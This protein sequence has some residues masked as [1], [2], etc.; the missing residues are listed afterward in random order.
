[1][2]GVWNAVLSKAC[3]L[4]LNERQHACGVEGGVNVSSC[5]SLSVDQMNANRLSATGK[6]QYTTYLG[7]YYVLVVAALLCTHQCVSWITFGPIP[8]EASDKYGLTDLEITL[9]PGNYTLI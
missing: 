9:L 8:Q 7:R 4:R 2:G 5:G 1:M 6:H 3:A